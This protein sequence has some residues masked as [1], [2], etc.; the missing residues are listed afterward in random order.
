MKTLTQRVI[1]SIL[2][3]DQR[4]LDGLLRKLKEVSP[5]V[6]LDVVD[7]KFAANHSLDF[8]FHLPKGFAYTAHIMTNHPQGWIK[9]YFSKIEV[10]IP[11]I[12]TVRDLPRYIS[13]MKKK[14]KRVAF[15]LKPE[16]SVR[17]IKPHLKQIDIVLVLTVHPGFY[18][19]KFLRAPLRKIK[20]LKAANPK[21]KIIVD[22]QMNPQT[23]KLAAQ[24]GGD[25]FISGS[26][27][28]NAENAMQ[29][30]QELLQQLR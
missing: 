15:A 2:A 24:A 21:V 7:G 3:K 26:Y 18:G 20:V 8:T 25:Y 13:W 28:N 27:V 16:T 12:E 14:K 30:I 23:I 1:P 9:K 5:E 4:E 19:S 17:R 11:Q 6:H 29:A 22:G 10:F